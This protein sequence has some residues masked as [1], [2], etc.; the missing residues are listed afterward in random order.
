MTYIVQYDSSRAVVARWQRA[1]AWPGPGAELVTLMSYM[2]EGVRSSDA[3]GASLLEVHTV[4]GSSLRDTVTLFIKS[5]DIIE[6]K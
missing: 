1:W 2:K 5:N 3:A 4:D 6:N